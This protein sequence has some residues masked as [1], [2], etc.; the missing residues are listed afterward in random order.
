MMDQR[1]PKQVSKIIL[2][3]IWSKIYN[4][5]YTTLSL[6][7]LD[8]EAISQEIERIDKTIAD[9]DS[10]IKSTAEHNPLRTQA[11]EFK[12]RRLCKISLSFDCLKW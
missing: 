11:G 2:K 7:W 3:N 4:L 12:R 8:N 9:I 6:I 1:S 5:S 10:A